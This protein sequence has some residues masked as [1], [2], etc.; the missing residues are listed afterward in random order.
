MLQKKG[1]YQ[2]NQMDIEEGEIQVRHDDQTMEDLI[3][4][5][6][7]IVFSVFVLT[8]AFICLFYVLK[9]FPKK[10]G[11]SLGIMREIEHLDTRQYEDLKL[12]YI[13]RKMARNNTKNMDDG[14]ISIGGSTRYTERDDEEKN[15]GAFGRA[16]DFIFSE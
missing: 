13:R 14:D 7:V 11:Q 1:A 16:M 6:S 8:I 9:I 2:G 5:T 3:Q 15:R 4:G 12:E 10:R